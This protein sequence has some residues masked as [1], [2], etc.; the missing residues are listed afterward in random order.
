MTRAFKQRKFFAA[1]VFTLLAVLGSFGSTAQTQR[2]IRGIV[3]D[4]QKNPVTGASVLVRESTTATRTDDGGKF[5][6]L[7]PADK[8]ILVISY[9]GKAAQE[10]NV[11]NQGFVS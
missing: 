1:M 8:H 9:I 3:L 7:L 5:S 10:I 2:T 6:L 11:R 4:A